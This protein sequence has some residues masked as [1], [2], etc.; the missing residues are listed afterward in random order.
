M[1]IEKSVK[2]FGQDYR[3]ED[4]P[5]PIKELQDRKNDNICVGKE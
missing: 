5:H 2:K 4:K 1:V 3:Y